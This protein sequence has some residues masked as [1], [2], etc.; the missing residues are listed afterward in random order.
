[1]VIIDNIFLSPY[2]PEL[3]AG[4]LMLGPTNFNEMFWGVKSHHLR[5]LGFD[6]RLAGGRAEVLQS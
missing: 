6:F 4:D 3:I 1:M 2:L 5:S